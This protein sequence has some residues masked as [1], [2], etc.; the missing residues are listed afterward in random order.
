MLGIERRW[1]AVT[2]LQVHASVIGVLRLL[3]R[4]W[5]WVYRD[6]CCVYDAAREAGSAGGALA[7]S[8]GGILERVHGMI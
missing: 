4:E 6:A 2:R 3:T 8:S 1:M 7:P 5:S